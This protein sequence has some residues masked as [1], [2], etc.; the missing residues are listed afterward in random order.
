[1][2][3]KIELMEDGKYVRLT[4]VSVV[5][6]KEHEEFRAKA[7]T[8][9]AD[10]G[11]TKV[12]IDATQASVEMS[13]LNDYE[14]TSNYQSHLPPKLRTAIVYRADEAKAKRYQFI[15]DVARNRGVGIRTFTDEI[16]ALAWLHDG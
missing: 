10:I 15:E 5:T 12:L 4:L 11:W 8:A 14:V 7:L 16:Q 1:M 2:A 9:L 3:Y 13:I 6:M